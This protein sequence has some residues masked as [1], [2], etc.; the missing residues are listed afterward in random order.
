MISLVTQAERRRV[1]KLS[2]CYLCGESFAGGA[3]TNRDHVPPDS[4]FWA[5]HKDPLI[6]P[7][8]RACNSKHSLDDEKI[9]QLIALKFG[10]IPKDP[11]NHRLA[12]DLKTGALTNLDIDGVVWRWISGFHASLY[13]QPVLNIRRFCTLVTPFPRGRAV[14]GVENIEPLKPQHSLFVQTIKA[15]R[16]KGNVD[17]IECNRGNLTYEC[18]W[19]RADNSGPWACF[20]ALNVYDWKD[21]GHARGQAARG[22]AGSYSLLLSAAPERASIADRDTANASGDDLLDPFS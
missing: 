18:V 8:H 21:L 20:F 15:N 12:I 11:N 6:L 19:C 7:T 5:D 14:N 22:C 17:R 9:S 2:F 3:V 4:V 13:Q 10:K 16:A 1:Q